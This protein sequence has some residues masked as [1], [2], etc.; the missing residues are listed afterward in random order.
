MKLAIQLLPDL[1]TTMDTAG[2][3]GYLLI[4]I[5]LIAVI[6]RIWRD[7]KKEENFRK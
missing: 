5:F 7:N 3:I 4:L 6:I 1:N 2:F